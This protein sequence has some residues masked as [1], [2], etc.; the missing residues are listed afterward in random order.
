MK[1]EA[2]AK[3]VIQ[4]HRAL[5]RDD[6][7]VEQLE[8]EWKAYWPH[9]ELSRAA[10]GR[11]GEELAH[12]LEA[13]GVSGRAVFT[14]IYSRITFNKD[15]LRSWLRERFPRPCAACGL[16]AAAQY[17]SDRR[18]IALVLGDIE[19]EEKMGEIARRQTAAILK[20]DGAPLWLELERMRERLD[21]G[22]R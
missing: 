10:S 17:T 11:N 19:L 3:A 5:V 18:A 14:E 15:A 21:H 22:S 13:S 1:A 16:Y 6:F 7:H 20:R 9:P 4:H 2:H 8:G 12:A